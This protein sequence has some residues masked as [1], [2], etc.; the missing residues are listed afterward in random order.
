MAGKK[1]NGQ[2][3]LGENIGDNGG[4]NIAFRA[5]QNV[6]KTEKLGVKDGFTPEQRFFLSWAR[7]WAGNA[8]PEYL[9]YLMTVDVHSPNEAR[10]NG[11]LPMVDAWYKAFGIKKGEKL[12]V[13]KNKRAHIW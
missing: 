3:T 12:F 7:V 8:R 11:A 5:L 2:L 13:P 4:L 6:M 1:V 9:Q 10:V